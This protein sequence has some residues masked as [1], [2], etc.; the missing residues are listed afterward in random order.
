MS[1][2]SGGIRSS[3]VASWTAD[4]VLYPA[5]YSLT[6]HNHGLQHQSFNFPAGSRHNT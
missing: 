1:A 4:T 6:V 2:G 3:V 5:K